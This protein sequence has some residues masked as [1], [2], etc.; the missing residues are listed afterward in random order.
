MYSYSYLEQKEFLAPNPI[1]SSQYTSDHIGTFFISLMLPFTDSIVWNR[2]PQGQW[3]IA[4][5]E[6]SYLLNDVA[7]VSECQNICLDQSPCHSM[8][9]SNS[10]QKCMTHNFTR[11]EAYA[12]GRWS[13]SEG[14]EYMDVFYSLEGILPHKVWKCYIWHIASFY[15]RHI[16]T[17]NSKQVPVFI[18]TRIMHFTV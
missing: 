18:N 6:D 16:H 5:A 3:A 2:S 1:T 4:V 11:L 10:T 17:A 12:Y 14:V 7:D 15:S 13:V 9:Y 8:Q